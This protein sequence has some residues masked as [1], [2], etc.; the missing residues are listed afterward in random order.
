MK[1]NSKKKTYLIWTNPT[2]YKVSVE[3]PL[4]LLIQALALL[5]DGVKGGQKKAV[6]KL[7]SNGPL[8][9]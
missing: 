6:L 3:R 2:G 4:E 5:F 8:L 1:S 9:L 7:S